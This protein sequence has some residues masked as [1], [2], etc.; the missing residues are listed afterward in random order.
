MNESIKAIRGMNDILPTMTGWWQRV[1][2]ILR[3]TAMA[4]GYEEIRLPVV[5]MTP[6]YARAIGEV[7]DIVEKEMY[8]FADRGGESLTLRPEGTAGCV[9]AAL[10]HGLLH[11]QSAKLYYSGPMF[12]YERPQK[13]RYRQFHQFGME[14][15]GLS[16]PDIDAELILVCARLWQALGIADHVHLEINSLGDADARVSYRQALVNYLNIHRSVL[17]EDSQRRLDSNPLR[18]LDSK[19]P[20]TQEVLNNAPILADYLDEAAAEH[21]ATLRALLDK[22]GV[23]YRVNPRLVRGLDYYNRA[24]FEWVTTALGAQGTVCAGGRYDGLVAQLGGSPTPAVGMAMGMERLILLCQEVTEAQVSRQADVMVLGQGEGYSGAA[25]VLAEKIRDGLTG[26]R[27]LV[28]MGGGGFKSQFRRADRSGAR[29][30]LIL[31]EDEMAT[32][33]V[34]IKWLREERDQEVMSQEEAVVW[35]RAH[36]AL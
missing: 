24:V 13:G 15:L 34:T 31:G 19:H 5:E 7:T 30:A 17:D 16:G 32:G 21:F 22:A 8:S 25:L 23:V 4:Y 35:L 20:A 27:V 11:N 36:F 12:R 3:D 29:F 1:E 33:R 28:H 6:L 9:R 14:S 26:L 2:D 18:V 10:E